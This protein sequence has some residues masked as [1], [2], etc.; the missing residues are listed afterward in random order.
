MRNDRQDTFPAAYALRTLNAS[1]DAVRAA[2]CSGTD[3]AKPIDRTTNR[4][5]DEIAHN[6]ASLWSET[7]DLSFDA[8]RLLDLATN[9]RALSL[10]SAAMRTVETHHASARVALRGVAEMLG[11]TGMVS[12]L[13]VSFIAP[14][15]A[16][17]DN[18]PTTL[19]ARSWGRVFG[20]WG[21]FFC[22]RTV[23]RT[24]ASV[25]V[26]RRSLDTYLQ[27]LETLNQR[28]LTS[29]A[30]ALTEYI[31]R[32]ERVRDQGDEGIQP[33]VQRLK[34]DLAIISDTEHNDLSGR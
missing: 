2:I 12:A 28:S 16:V 1:R 34:N 9:A 29:L 18:L 33:N 10:S 19:L 11:L 24:S 22:A 31:E 30:Q 7:H 6:A 26:V 15:F 21:S 4:L 20:R 13:P 3:A 14:A 27:R 5:I 25:Q 8:T 17:Q 32:F 23:L